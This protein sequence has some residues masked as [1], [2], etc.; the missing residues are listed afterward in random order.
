MARESM[1]D[2]GQWISAA[3][4]TGNK[5]Q[6]CR[7]C[8]LPL[9]EGFDYIILTDGNYYHPECLIK[10]ANQLIITA[11]DCIKQNRI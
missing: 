11:E 4:F 8:N 6:Y 9:F 7:Y 5:S 10:H 1:I 3:I 2:Y